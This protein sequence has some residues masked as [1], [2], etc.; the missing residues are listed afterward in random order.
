MSA[1]LL[2]CVCAVGARRIFDNDEI[3]DMRGTLRNISDWI[4]HETDL[5]SNNIT[6]VRD[7]LKTSIFINGNLARTLLSAGQIFNNTLYLETGMKW[8]DTFVSLQHDQ[9]TNDGKHL[10]GFWDTGYATLYI[11]DTGTAV[12]ALA[13]CYDLSKDASRRYEYMRAMLKFS[14]FVVNG[15]LST[16]VCT[17]RKNC[18]YDADGNNTEV[19]SSWVRSDGSLG[20]GYYMQR[21]NKEPY[22][23]ATATTGG[24]FFAEMFAL[25]RRHDFEEAARKATAWLID[26]VQANGTIPYYIYPPTTVSHEYQCISYSAEAIIDSTLRGIH[27][28]SVDVMKRMVQYLLDH[29]QPNGELIDPTV[30]TVG[31]QQ[32]SPR[33]VSLLQWYHQV[34]SDD[35]AA[36]AVKK[37]WQFLQSPGAFDPEKYGV[38]SYALVTGFVGLALADL[39]EPWCTFSRLDWL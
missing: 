36:D 28:P 10:G 3:E 5:P 29:Q 35:R 4:V 9:I 21:I 16:P 14:D 37:Y 7:T 1:I 15:T 27:D 33:A 31:E 19:T 20:D 6:N 18:T 23:I 38:N 26:H 34:T 17:F 2:T 39:I 8:C 24:A 13:L 11:A 32:R 30:A 25:T 22:T 12:T